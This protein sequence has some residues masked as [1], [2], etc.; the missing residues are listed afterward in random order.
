M[1]TSPSSRCASVPSIITP[2]ISDFFSR[3]RLV[4]AGRVVL[5][6]RAW[7]GHGLDDLVRPARVPKLSRRVLRISLRCM[8]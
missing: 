1:Q 3:H 2:G 7:S 6:G 4:D 8:C 5:S